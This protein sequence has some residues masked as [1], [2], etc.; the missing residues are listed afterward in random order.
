MKAK[1]TTINN[2]STFYEN[3]LLRFVCFTTLRYF[4]TGA[5]V[6]SRAVVPRLVWLSCPSRGFMRVDRGV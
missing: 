5:I 2:T 6:S 4:A 1:K 3:S